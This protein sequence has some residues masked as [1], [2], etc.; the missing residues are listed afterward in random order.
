MNYLTA[1]LKS[2]PALKETTLIAGI[3]IFLAGCEDTGVR[4][5]DLCP[6]P[7]AVI[8]G[9][10]LIVNVGS[11]RKAKDSWA[12]VEMKS[13]GEKIYIYG[14]RVSEKQN[15]D[16]TFKLPQSV[17]PQTVPVVWVNP[18]GTKVSV[19]VSR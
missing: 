5:S 12:R 14:Y 3:L 8:S 18:G 19:R 6:A 16:F 1:F 4:Y 13:E 17:N 9:D 2:D 11:L 10:N 15:S 7:V